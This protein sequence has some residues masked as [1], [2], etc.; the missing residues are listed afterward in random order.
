VNVEWRLGELSR[1][2]IEAATRRI[3]AELTRLGLGRVRLADWLTEADDADWRGGL[4]WGHHQ[5]GTTRMSHDPATGVVNADCRMHHVDNLYVAG[6]SVFPTGG[7]ANPTLSIVAL[8][9]RLAEHLKTT[10]G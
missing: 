8:A 10:E 3:A 7:Y 9:L 5:M 1:R 4:H 2:T 6:A